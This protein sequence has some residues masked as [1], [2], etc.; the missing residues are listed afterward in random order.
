MYQSADPVLT[1]ALRWA[2]DHGSMDCPFA[3]H[4]FSSLFLP[5]PFALEVP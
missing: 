3:V 1:L 5:D 4:R 2:V